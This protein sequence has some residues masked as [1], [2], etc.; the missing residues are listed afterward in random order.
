MATTGAV[1]GSSIDV[2]SLVSQLVA[3]ERKPLD[4]QVARATAKVTTQISAVG[5]LMGA[6]SSFRSTLSSLKTTDVFNTRTATSSDAKIITGSATTSAQPGSYEVEVR[7][8]A[9]AHQISSTAFAQGSTQ[10]VGTG[11]LTVSLGAESFQVTIDSTNSTVG[12]IRD[13]INAAT[14]NPG[15]RATIINA[16]DGAHLVLTSDKTGETNAIQI[17]QTGADG[18]LAQLEYSA[19]NQVN[20]TQLRAA[21]DAIAYIATYEARSATNVIEGV[22]EGVSLNLVSASPGTTVNF[23]VGFDTKTAETRIRSF[24]E[25]YN[26]LRAQISR[27]SNYDAA[28]Q[29]AGPMLGD[30]LLTGID[31]EIRRTLSTP[32]AGAGD[33]YQTL[34]AIGIKTQANGTLAIDDT[35]LQAALGSQFESVSKLFGSTDGVAAR[36]YEQI[37]ARLEDGAGIDQ[38]NDTLLNERK[39]IE[40]R[41]AD[42]DT[43]MQ[44]VQQ[45]YLK[46]FTR[47]DTLLSSLQSTSAFLSQQI[48]SLANLNKRD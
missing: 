27:L 33:M 5:A 44:I 14:G 35:K 30:A 8:L 34:A 31:A 37:G 40:K 2:N 38:R 19:S 48:E 21:Q 46:Q 6:L 22:I 13:A 26:A 29:T 10:N 12:G 42:I 9:S 18:N 41:K 11:T 47:L 36:L 24:V 39:A 3:A 28:S 15:V 20:Y 43:R 1:G 4:D 45:T 25:G 23:N 16:Q 32:V 7:Q 17:S